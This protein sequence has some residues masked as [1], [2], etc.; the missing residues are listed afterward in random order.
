[1]VI[2]HEDLVKA[3]RLFSAVIME[4][5]IKLKVINHDFLTF[6]HTLFLIDNETQMMYY[7]VSRP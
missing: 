5:K 7:N 6:P 4:M 2:V 1:M 3:K